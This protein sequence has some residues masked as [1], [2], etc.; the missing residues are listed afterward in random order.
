MFIYFFLQNV[1]SLEIG[2]KVNLELLNY[3]K[4]NYF[5]KINF[6]IKIIL[7]LLTDLRVIKKYKDLNKINF[8][9]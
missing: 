2:L 9:I 3:K 1:Q 8:K 4:I 5:D 6:L 7:I